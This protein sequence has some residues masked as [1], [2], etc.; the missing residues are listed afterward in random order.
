MEFQSTESIL[1]SPSSPSPFILF[2]LPWAHTKHI[3][4]HAQRRGAAG[5]D[6]RARG[7]VLKSIARIEIW[8]RQE[9]WSAASILLCDSRRREPLPPA[10]GD[11]SWSQEYKKKIVQ[12]LPRSRAE[13]RREKITGPA[14]KKKTM[15]LSQSN[16][17]KE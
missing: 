12:N 3:H 10:P 2:F 11:S 17:L 8:G 1:S 9:D 15:L 7:G 4:I 16:G 14:E 5:K 6:A 13:R